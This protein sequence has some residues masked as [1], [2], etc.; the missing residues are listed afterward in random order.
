MSTYLFH[1]QGRQIV[2]RSVWLEFK[3]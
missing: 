3:T 2:Y 1:F